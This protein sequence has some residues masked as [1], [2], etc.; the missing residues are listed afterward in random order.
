MREGSKGCTHACMRTKPSNIGEVVSP[1]QL[2]N[3]AKASGGPVR[4]AKEY[5]T[6]SRDSE[7]GK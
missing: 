2:N 7:G 4:R 3:S 1:A 5:D 6:R